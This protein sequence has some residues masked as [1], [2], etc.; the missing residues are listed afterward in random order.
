MLGSALLS[1]V[2]LSSAPALAGTGWHGRFVNKVDVP[3]M[4]EKTKDKPDCWYPRDFNKQT[5]ILP[6]NTK[7]KSSGLPVEV[8]N[9]YS[10]TENSGHCNGPIVGNTSYHQKFQ[11]TPITKP[12]T[13]PV[14]G[15][16]KMTWVGS[17]NFDGH[18]WCQLEVNDTDPNLSPPSKK[19][20]NPEDDTMGYGVVV[21]Y[22]PRTEFAPF[23]DRSKPNIDWKRDAV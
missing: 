8:V 4:V 1:V 7:K 17:N 9:L 14:T 6:L 3:I 21:F 23:F 15:T 22:D 5:T 2:L 13:P 12:S 10:E 19:V 18:Y 16:L 20:C 11:I